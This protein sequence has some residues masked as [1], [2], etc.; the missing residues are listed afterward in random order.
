MLTISFLDKDKVANTL[1]PDL[2]LDHVL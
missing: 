1:K 2:I